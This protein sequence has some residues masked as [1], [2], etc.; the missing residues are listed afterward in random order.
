MYAQARRHGARPRHRAGRLP[1]DRRAPRRH[2]LGRRTIR[3][4]GQPVQLHPSALT[5][6][7]ST[8][9]RRRFG[10]MDASM[11]PPL[12]PLDETW[13]RALCI[14]AH[15]DDMEFGAAAAVA[16]WTGPGQVGRLHDGHQRR[17]RH[18]RHAARRVPHRPRGRA[19]RVGAH[20]RCRHG[21]LPAPARR[22]P[23][24]RRADAP[25]A[26]RRG[27]SSPSR[28]R[29]HRELPRHLGRPQPQPGRPHRRRQGGARRG[30][31]LPATGGSS[32][33]SSR[34]RARAVG[35]R[36]RRCGRS[37]PP[38]SDHGVDTTDTFDAGVESL[39]AHAAYIE[40]L[41]WENWDPRRVPRRDG[42]GHRPAARG[43]RSPHRS[44]C[45]RWA[46][47]T[48]DQ[49]ARWHNR[50][51]PAWGARAVVLAADR[52]PAGRAPSGRHRGIDRFA[53]KAFGARL[54]AYPL[55]MLLAPALVVVHGAPTRPG[56]L[57]RRTAP[58]TLVIAAVPRRRDLAT[59]WT[60]TTRSCG[61]TTSTHS[62][63]TGCC[64]CSGIGLAASRATCR[65]DWATGRPGGT[66]WARVLAMR[67][68]AG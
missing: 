4:R 14:V 32:R 58:S 38:Q 62:E 37:A 61:G 65:P 50:S 29:D 52:R 57:R 13:E 17:G 64:S 41:G 20:R 24:V 33:S 2:D 60:S 16:R 59:A 22:R 5:A 66:G 51:C 11:P 48:D 10:A 19:G 56:P 43:R 9:S 34:G 63:S 6:L 7:P 27:A 39:K 31:R 54:L 23:G 53:D 28:H 46:G 67:L 30:A 55:L 47:A 15:P 44:R 25:A 68:G 49:L 12:E 21:R 1:T 36:T 42:P 45:S 40:G 35:R 8:R 3:G 18:R 26:R